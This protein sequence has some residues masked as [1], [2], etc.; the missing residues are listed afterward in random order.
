M[1]LFF[2][3]RIWA[4][5]VPRGRPCCTRGEDNLSAP[6]TLFYF[7]WEKFQKANGHSSR[8][9]PLHSRCADVLAAWEEQTISGAVTFCFLEFIKCGMPDPWHFCWS[10][11]FS[12]VLEI[13]C[14]DFETPFLWVWHVWGHLVCTHFAFVFHWLQQV[15][16]STFNYF[17]WFES[18]GSNP[19]IE[20]TN[21]SIIKLFFDWCGLKYSSIIFCF[22]WEGSFVECPLLLL[23]IYIHR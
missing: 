6:L 3:E 22:I 14:D 20:W 8:D 17:H 21:E 4:V 12:K 5:L 13:P 10:F 9:C 15:W 7:L 16:L 2:F 18:F 19:S 1:S 11:L 23:P